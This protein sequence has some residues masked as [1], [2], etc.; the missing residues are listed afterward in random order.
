MQDNAPDLSMDYSF[1]LDSPELDRN[2]STSPSSQHNFH[3][4][5]ISN[6]A[7]MAHSKV[8]GMSAQR[9]EA[10]PLTGLVT[11]H[12]KQ[13]VSSS[14]YRSRGSIMATGARTRIDDGGISE[15]NKAKRAAPKHCSAFL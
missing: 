7:N 4:F 10:G 13:E 1:L 12:H 15:G 6:M 9:A 8:P 2:D 14:L 5:A 11:P 3:R